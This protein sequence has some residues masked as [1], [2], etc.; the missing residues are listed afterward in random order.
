MEKMWSV[1]FLRYDSGAGKWVPTGTDCPFWTMCTEKK[2][3][4][5]TAIRDYP[6]TWRISHVVIV[7]RSKENL[8]FTRVRQ[9]YGEYFRLYYKPNSQNHV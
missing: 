1:T 4:I 9:G 2:N 8:L 7:S 3:V 5:D 6:N